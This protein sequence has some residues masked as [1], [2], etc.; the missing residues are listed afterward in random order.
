MN[1]HGQSDVSASVPFFMFHQPTKKEEPID[2]EL[3][4]DQVSPVLEP[5]PVVK[6]S[7][8]IR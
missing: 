6:Q 1:V 8:M 3:E 4:R 5:P 7:R 2:D